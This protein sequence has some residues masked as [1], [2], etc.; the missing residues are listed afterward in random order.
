MAAA[1]ILRLSRP[2]ALGSASLILVAIALSPL[3]Q[4]AAARRG[5]A[6]VRPVSIAYNQGVAYDGA[7]GGWYFSGATSTTNSGLFRTDS[8]LRPTAGRYAVIPPGPERFNHIGDLTL[9]RVRRRLLLPLE[10]YYPRGGGN[11]CGRAAIGV[12]DPH[13]LAFRYR[14]R[15]STSQI[16]KAA[17][18]EASP[19]ARWIWTS[20]GTHLLAYAAADVNP[21]MALRQRAGAGGIVGRDLG[22]LLPTAG[23]TGAA[24]S[25]STAGRYRLLLSLNRGSFFQV[26]SYAVATA[27]D[28]SPLIADPRPRVEASLRRSALNREPEGLAVSPRRLGAYPLGGSLHWQVRPAV[29]L[30]MRLLA[31]LV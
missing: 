30:Y 17:W 14:V 8:R 25:G 29:S 15:L 13:T 19:D 5:L 9:D 21:A 11:V 22:P 23:V 26:V 2:L 31:Y 6:S 10:C 24:V 7:T 1:R 28:G 12:A 3:V 20:A 27:A 18:V 16:V 4:P